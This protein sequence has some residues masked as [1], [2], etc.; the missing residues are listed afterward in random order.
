MKYYY[1]GGKEIPQILKTIKVS[2]LAFLLGMC[3]IPAT[4]AET[5]ETQ[6]IQQAKQITGQVVDAQNEPLIGVSI[7]VKGTTT[8]TV[9]DFDGNY[10]IQAATGNV[11]VF[12]YIGYTAQEVAV[13]NQARI[14]VKL[15]DDALALEE[16]VVVGYGTLK[17]KE[18]TSSVETVSAKDFNQGGSRNALDLIQGKIAG[19]N[20]TRIDGSDPNSGMNIQ[21]RGV[22]SLSGTRTPLI[23]IDGIPGG[24]LDLLQQD[25]I[26][27][28]SVLKDG[29][30]SA[31]Y[32]TRGNSGVI[33]I[34]TKKGK[35]GAPQFDYNTY[36]QHEVVAKTPDVFN[37][38]EWRD[39][40]KQGVI[41]A[42][43]DFGGDTD[44]FDELINKNN[45]SHY[46]NFSMSGGT[47]NTNYRASVFFNQAEGLVMENGRKQ[48]GGRIN[49]NQK[50]L[51]DR[52]TVSMNLATNMS[53]ANL[54]GGTD[55]GDDDDREG[56][57]KSAF[58]QAIQRN[59]TA[60]IKNADGTFY[61]TFAFNNHN[62]MSRF[63]NRLRRREQ[64]T[65][66]GDVKAR[67]D[68]I[69]GLSASVFGSYQRNSYNDRYY[70]AS[71]D[72]DNREG[73]KY[74]GMGYAEKA[75][76]LKW[77]KMLETTI[78]YR[79]VINEVHS[80]TAL[81]GYSYQYETWERTKMTMSGFTTDAFKD[82]NMGAGTATNNT[83]LDRP[84]Q[85]SEKKDNTLVSFFGRLNYSY[86]DRYHVQAIVRH[87]GSSKF[88]ANHKW[89]TFPSI[90][91]GWTVSEEAFME[92]VSWLD[93]LKFRVG[94]GVTGNQ[95][96]DE[97]QS[98]VRLGTGGV[99][100]QNGV[101]YQTYGAANNPN[102]DLKWEQKGE[103]NIG[104]DFGLLN[105]RITGSIDF[106]NRNTKDILY[107]YSAQ[108]PPY[109][110]D[111]IWMNIG[112]LRSR[113]VEFQIS[114]DVVQSKDF[115]YSVDIAASTLSNKLTK[116]SSDVFKVNWLSFYGLPSPGNLGD[117]YRLYEDGSP[118]DFYGKRFAGFTDDGKWLFYKADGS[119][120][121]STELSDDDL[122]KI[123]NGVPKF[124]LS[125]NNR[126]TYKNFDLTMMFRG[127]F[128]FDILNVKEMYFGNKKWL[129]N[130]MF[131]SAINKHSELD[132]DPQYSDYYLE[133]GDYMKLDNLTLG[134]TF[135]NLKTPYLR[136]LRIYATGRN[137]FTIT[138]YSG[139]DPELDD[140]GFEPSKDTRDYYPKSRT[141]T[142]GLS[143]GF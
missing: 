106:F 100:P 128:G 115:N 101:Y 18:V 32:G 52:L 117:A 59:P 103:L 50:G 90:S 140:S 58:E 63:E 35:S 51:Q 60:P 136:T 69:E 12:S 27:S 57:A 75:T 121:R 10:S 14:N 45:I 31:I 81:A 104:I 4:Y 135:K 26:E 120:V 143:I 21:L 99:Y 141:F 11:L 46:H 112:T 77:Q 118:G 114:G 15:L 72:W 73:T 56:I 129:P 139:M 127:K 133:K 94:Y 95:G 123:G 9:T 8:G 65:T 30:A 38:S 34:T 28:I 41:D 80:I 110:R 108:Q 132:D 130:N 36:I 78:D 7:Q 87:E 54:L 97:Y 37:A 68:I 66:S 105:R 6:G 131:K 44:L 1:L 84:E 49:V 107:E 23:V 62:P 102:P 125:F 93:E 92:E 137:L 33:L 5:M 55:N 39:L 119:V 20:M 70:Q 74:Q 19:L 29:S 88:G 43:E 111:K 16:V 13:G 25:D 96:I 113:G 82:W 71:T 142:F 134:Y 48:Y 83:Q 40:I 61:E 67:L 53:K 116:L 79:K 64:Q 42:S 91:G 126:I 76:Y 3:I 138:G 24:N 124:Q 122:V 85:E 89:G 2:I 86:H 22:S 17:R 47:A 98:L 109:V